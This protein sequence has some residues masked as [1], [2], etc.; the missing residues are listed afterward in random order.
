MLAV[1]HAERP[2]NA[3]FIGGLGCLAW[4]RCFRKHRNLENLILPRAE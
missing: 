3:L 2:V 1:L 4:L